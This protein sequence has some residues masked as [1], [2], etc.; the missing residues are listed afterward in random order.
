LFENVRRCIRSK[1]IDEEDAAEGPRQVNTYENP[2]EVKFL[3][4]HC[5]NINI[6]IKTVGSTKN[7]K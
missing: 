3:Y 7:T 2:Y 1:L 5:Y 6:I 4:F